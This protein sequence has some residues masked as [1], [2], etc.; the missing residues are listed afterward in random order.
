MTHPLTE[1]HRTRMAALRAGLLLWVQSLW[2]EHFNEEQAT[3]TLTAIGAAV[4]ARVTQAQAVAVSE[5][6]DWLRALIAAATGLPVAEVAPFTAGLDLVGSAA[7]LNQTVPGLTRMAPAVYAARVG[8]GQDRAAAADSSLAWL[9]RV[10]ASEPYR[11]ANQATL[12]A[13]VDDERL[14]GRVVRVTAA[15]PCEFCAE[16]ADRGYLSAHADFEAHNHCRC[17]A[18]P[19]ISSHVTSRYGIRRARLAAQGLSAAATR[20]RAAAP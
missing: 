13:S 17:S 8:A 10:A 2:R 15:D 20:S 12:T 6:Q 7:A 1:L 4:G 11:V 19:E 5:T 14:T 9:N 18:E 16:I 3:E